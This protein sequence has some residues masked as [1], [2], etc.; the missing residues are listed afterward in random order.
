MSPSMCSHKAIA[1]LVSNTDH[2]WAA[3]IDLWPIS[4]LNHEVTEPVQ[5]FFSKFGGR[6]TFKM[7][8]YL[9]VPIVAQWK[10]I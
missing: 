8:M 4:L 9:G 6:T 2:I 7:G 5:F 10:Q 3:L 1:Y